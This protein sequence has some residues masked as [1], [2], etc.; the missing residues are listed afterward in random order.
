MIARLGLYKVYIR[1]D[2]PGMCLEVLTTK[3]QPLTTALTMRTKKPKPFKNTVEVKRQ[4][5][6]RV[7][8]PPAAVT[9]TDKRLKPPKHKKRV[10]VAEPEVS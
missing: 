5:R 4:A 7:G 1:G 8:S 9:H 2:A 10:D 3:H 6:L